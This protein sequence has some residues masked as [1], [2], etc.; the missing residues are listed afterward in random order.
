[1]GDEMRD[2]GEVRAHEVKMRGWTEEGVKIPCIL[3]YTYIVV[4]TTRD[5]KSDRIK[6]L[7][8]SQLSLLGTFLLTMGFSSWGLLNGNVRGHHNVASPAMH[9]QCQWMWITGSI[10]N[11]TLIFNLNF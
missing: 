4:R 5:E 9:A 10:L 6:K 3:T 7:L 1:M 11:Q 8:L 2:M